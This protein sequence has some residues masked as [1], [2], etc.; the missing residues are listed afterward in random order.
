MNRTQ[1]NNAAIASDILSHEDLSVIEFVENDH[2]YWFD[3]MEEKMF[4][5]QEYKDLCAYGRNSEL[6]NMRQKGLN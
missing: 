6:P 5:A 1:I 2:D 3:D 4:Y